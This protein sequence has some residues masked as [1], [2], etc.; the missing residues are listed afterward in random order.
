MF[1]VV[2]TKCQRTNE[3]RNATNSSSRI[4]VYELTSLCSMFNF[5]PGRILVNKLIILLHALKDLDST[6]DL[7]AVASCLCR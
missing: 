1:Y 4:H 5:R 3:F 7:C 6:L 2:V